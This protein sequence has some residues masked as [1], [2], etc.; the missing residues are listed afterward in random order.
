MLTYNNKDVHSATGLTPYKARNKENE[1]R[2]KANIASK[3]KK[4]RLYPELMVGDRV[5]NLTKK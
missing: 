3:A 5:K 2:A 4:E 1:L